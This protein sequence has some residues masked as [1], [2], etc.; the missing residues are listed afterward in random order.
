LWSNGQIEVHHIRKLADLEKGKSERPDWM[1]RWL[2]ATPQNFGVP[3]MS[4]QKIQ[5]G[6][7]DGKALHVEITGERYR[8]VMRR[9]G[10]DWKRYASTG[11][12]LVAYPTSC[13]V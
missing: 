1:K 8:K 5:Y 6:R 9:G 10:G 11:N 4:S 3:G 2:H 12:S 7:Y 13:T